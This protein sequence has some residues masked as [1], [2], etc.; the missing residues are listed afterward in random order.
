MHPA[1]RKP[2][3]APGRNALLWFLFFLICMGLGYPTLN[4]YDPRQIDGLYDTRAYFAMVTGA[5]LQ[6]D[7]TDLSQRVLVPYLAKP[8]YWL[9]V[10]RLK[11]WNPVFFALLVS[12]SFFAATSAFLLVSISGRFIRD[13]PI[14]L[15]AGLIYLA[16]FAVANFNL[17]GYVDSSVNCMLLL[18]ALALFQEKWWIL[19][20]LGVLGALTKETFIP[21]AVAFAFAWWAANHKPGGRKITQLAWIAS[22]AVFSLGIVFWIMSAGRYPNTPFNFAASRQSSSGAG[23]L[24]LSGLLRCLR[25][26]EFIYVFIWLLPLGLVRLNRLPRPWVAASV[27]AALTAL[28]LGAYDDALGNATRAIF[29]ACGPVLSLSVALLLA[30]A[31][32]LN[33]QSAV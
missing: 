18:V 24:Y 10:G 7:Q 31:P 29:S 12:N 27:A 2:T 16:N 15:L 5:P 17:S 4:R 19:P 33:G 26:R 1:G 22:M 8:V 21:L 13:R 9:A 3:T 28:A 11:T 23:F 32:M 25:A 30:E 20:F 14:S 6:S